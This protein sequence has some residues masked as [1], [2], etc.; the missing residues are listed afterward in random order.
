MMLPALLH[1]PTCIDSPAV[2][3]KSW[4]GID[5]DPSAAC[6]PRENVF[7]PKEESAVSPRRSQRGV[8]CVDSS[9]HAHPEDAVSAIRRDRDTRAV[10]RA[11]EGRACRTLARR[12]L[13]TNA[14]AHAGLKLPAS[15]AGRRRWPCRPAG[16]RCLPAETIS[17]LGGTDIWNSSQ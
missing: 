14:C 6:V 16:L 10:R 9:A 4:A 13:C 15:A 7:S 3:A 2:C 17:E 5:V 1:R 11:E 8:V 12:H